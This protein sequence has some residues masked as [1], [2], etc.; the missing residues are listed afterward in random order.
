MVGK[1]STENGC[2]KYVVILNSSEVQY[3]LEFCIV[4]GYGIATFIAY[5]ERELS[6]YTSCALVAAP[7]VGS[8]IDCSIH[9]SEG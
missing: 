1:S 6:Y 3:V 7:Y 2:N 8:S 5:G 4:T 9:I